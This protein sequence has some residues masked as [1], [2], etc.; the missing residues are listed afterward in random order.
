MKAIVDKNTYSFGLAELGSTSVLDIFEDN[1][2]RIWIALDSDGIAVISYTFESNEIK[3]YTVENYTV[4]DGFQGNVKSITQ[5]NGLDYIS[6]GNLNPA[7]IYLTWSNSSNIYPNT[8]LTRSRTEVRPA[9]EDVVYNFN[10]VSGRVF[11]IQEDTIDI[12]SGNQ[13]VWKIV[14]QN[15]SSN[16]GQA[17]VTN[18]LSGKYMLVNSR[19]NDESRLVIANT[20]DS[21]YIQRFAGESAPTSQ[22]KNFLVSEK[23]EDNTYV[24]FAGDSDLIN[25]SL[26]D[27]NIVSP[28]TY[29]Y[30]LDYFDANGRRVEID[31]KKVIVS[32]TSQ[33]AENS[34]KIIIATDRGLWTFVGG[35]TPFS[36]K[37][38]F[39]EAENVTELFV[40]TSN[41]LYVSA[42]NILIQITDAGR[43]DLGKGDLFADNFSEISS[44]E[45]EIRNVIEGSSQELIIAT[46]LGISIR[47]PD[48]TF[49]SFIG[50]DS[51]V[52]YRSNNQFLINYWRPVKEISDGVGLVQFFETNNNN[53]KFFSYQNSIWKTENFGKNWIEH[54]R[55]SENIYGGSSIVDSSENVIDYVLYSKNLIFSTGQADIS[56]DFSIE[57]TKENISSFENSDRASIKGSPAHIYLSEAS[58]SSENPMLFAGVFDNRILE[59]EV[60]IISFSLGSEDNS[61]KDPGLVIGTSTIGSSEGLEIQSVYRIA[62]DSSGNLYAGAK[63]N[64]LI[65][66]NGSTWSPLEFVEN[67]DS[68]LGLEHCYTDLFIRDE[69]GVGRGIETERIIYATRTPIYGR[70]THDFVLIRPNESDLEKRITSIDVENSFIKN[71]SW[72]D[73]PGRNEYN[74]EATNHFSIGNH[75]GSI[76]FDAISNVLLIGGFDNKL[77]LVPFT[78][79]VNDKIRNSY[80]SISLI[81]G[82]RYREATQFSITSQFDT[83]KQV[84]GSGSRDLYDTKF[85]PRSSWGISFLENESKEE[86][87]FSNLI[88]GKNQS[89]FETYYEHT[90]LNNSAFIYKSFMSDMMFWEPFIS[91]NQPK[92]IITDFKYY[93]SELY[94]S[95]IYGSGH[96]NIGLFKIDSSNIWTKQHR[97]LSGAEQ[98]YFNIPINKLN[99]Q[100]SEIIIPTLGFG[101]HKFDSEYN[102]FAS[103]FFT[104]YGVDYGKW[105]VTSISQDPNNINTIF[106]GTLDR[107]LI[108][109][110]YSATDE[111]NTNFIWKWSVE[112]YGFES[113][114]ITDVEILSVNSEIV[115]AGIKEDGLYRKDPETKIYSKITDGIPS[116][117]DVLK[118]KINTFVSRIENSVP[119]LNEGKNILIIR[120]AYENPRQDPVDGQEYKLNN[121]VFNAQ[122]VYIGSDDFSENIFI[123]R[124]VTLKTG[125]PYFYRIYDIESNNIYSERDLI[126]GITRD[127]GNLY[128]DVVGDIFNSKDLSGRIATINTVLVRPLAF[129]ISNNNYNSSMNRSRVELI[130]DKFRVINQGNADI[131]DRYSIPYRIESTI[132]KRPRT[133]MPIWLIH[134]QDGSLYSKIYVSNDNGIKWIDKSNGIPSNADIFDIE[135]SNSDET[136][137]FVKH[138]LY[139]S[140]SIGVYVSTDDGTSWNKIS[141][142]TNGLPDTSY[143]KV[144]VDKGDYRIVYA[145]THSGNLYRSVNFGVS[146]D[147]LKDLGTGINDYT[148]ISE[149]SNSIFVGYDGLGINRFDDPVR[150][151]FTIQVD[152][153]SNI[154]NVE[155]EEFEMGDELFTDSNTIIAKTVSRNDNVLK[156][157]ERI[158]FKVDDET[159]FLTFRFNKKNKKYNLDEIRIGNDL[160]NPLTIP[161]I[162][163]NPE[164]DSGYIRINKVGSL[165]E[166]ENFLISNKGIHVTSNDG[167]TWQKLT[168]SFIPNDVR[169]LLS[170]KDGSIILAT[171]NG[172]WGS[173]INR[174]NYRNIEQD[175]FEVNTLWESF[176][177][178]VR[179]IF[180]GGEKGLYITV[181]R[182]LSKTIIVYSGDISQKKSI[183]FTWGDLV[184]P[185]DG[186]WT[187]RTEKVLSQSVWARPSTSSSLREYK[188]WD[189]G[190][191]VRYG[192]FTTFEKAETYANG[193]L[194]LP[195]NGAEY[196]SGFIAPSEGFSFGKSA[197]YENNDSGLLLEESSNQRT[198]TGVS[199]DI[200]YHTNGVIFLGNYPNINSPNN[201]PTG[202]NYPKTDFPI[203]DRV[204]AN[205]GEIRKIESEGNFKLT[206][207][208]YLENYADIRAYESLVTGGSSMTNEE[209]LVA[210]RLD[211]D[212]KSQIAPVLKSNMYYAYRVFPYRLI[213]DPTEVTLNGDFI[214]TP[215]YRVPSGD[216][217]E[218]YSF[219]IDIEKFTG[220]TKILTGTSTLSGNW[221]IGTDGGL[222]YSTENGQ[223]VIKSE[224][225]ST[226]LLGYSFVSILYTSSNVV[227]AVAV[228]SNLD[229][230]RFVR[231]ETD[232]TSTNFDSNWVFLNNISNYMKEMGINT[233]FNL[234]ESEDK[235]YAATN[236]GILVGNINGNDWKLVGRVGNVESTSGGKVIGQEFEI[237]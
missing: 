16:S 233:V 106:V 49:Y 162:L 211:S 48:N 192:P 171:N 44:K 59:E 203:I 218:S 221:I 184:N 97:A 72:V 43:T 178:G 58:S 1:L 12:G 157:Y 4:E 111:T 226:N 214:P 166:D 183:Q 19:E 135:I 46:N 99:S 93:N 90:P 188:G 219:V 45:L 14:A 47:R 176:D 161:F 160:V 110:V 138:I 5:I 113:G 126:T 91:T 179:R 33:G 174:K 173:D 61:N 200:F 71:I 128:F 237:E 175:S 235:I 142:G 108:K 129:E 76:Y 137:N 216:L 191:I 40:S 81:S 29:Y 141:I 170:A 68:E 234:E 24:L 151:E 36:V 208:G 66:T 228:S 164:Y 112:D 30:Y 187:D 42:G 182:P 220:S 204:D 15:F 105:N 146:W 195:V 205:V 202:N 63:G 54:A 117:G 199:E 41:I 84:I 104:Q 109:G 172:L 198:F 50:N 222:F 67:N 86:G 134:K 107:G 215:R 213:P 115:L 206:N 78:V 153:D 89:Y 212:A 23:I 34:S 127:I 37:N 85:M 94:A 227:L 92:G 13:I 79:D 7:S 75:R 196:P 180:R 210:L 55:L 74:W 207:N 121:E 120:S 136:R 6:Q 163:Q 2:G 130:S 149:F 69:T 201:Y 169:D 232:F 123:D 28:G 95:S 21:I 186:G 230:I 152:S 225:L 223:N 229:D 194:W 64:V 96:D 125:V 119:I 38:Q 56:S 77:F 25:S 144:L 148:I 101:I 98:Q 22:G 103:R 10:P 150:E 8:L 116:L 158:V 131:F 181:E 26:T 88:F 197:S 231:N 39:D 35:A 132:L 209:L 156:N 65:S 9:Y 143:N 102:S 70:R 193:N 52:Q 60:E 83:W 189:A 57:S 82:R 122:V 217:V 177:R 165:D 190:L 100:D 53:I 118:I 139:L 167:Q 159:K 236:R 11:S 27:F 87:Y 114:H 73:R 168:S 18:S 145:I 20:L 51:G 185:N 124:D 155:Y 32:S 133:V 31:S 62:E 140:T 80:N 3:N 224:N 147:F 17:I 154:T